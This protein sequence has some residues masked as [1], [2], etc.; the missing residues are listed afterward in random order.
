MAAQNESSETYS[1]PISDDDDF[2]LPDGTAATVIPNVG[3]SFNVDD[4]SEDVIKL[5]EP[6]NYQ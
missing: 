5:R 6:I 4:D 3:T 2:T 1:D